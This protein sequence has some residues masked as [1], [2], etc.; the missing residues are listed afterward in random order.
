MSKWTTKAQRDT[1]K[2]KSYKSIP[3]EHYNQKN[4]VPKQF[5]EVWE[6]TDEVKKWV[7]E[8]DKGNWWTE[9]AKE[10]Y[11]IFNGLYD[12]GYYPEG[13]DLIPPRLVK[14]MRATAQHRKKT[15]IYENGMKE[16]AIKLDP[17]E[18]KDW[19]DKN[20]LQAGI[21]DT[22]SADSLAKHGGLEFAISSVSKRLDYLDLSLIHI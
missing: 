11:Y 21:I 20:S 17:T 16:S 9:E 14:E 5:A 19:V 3:A 15:D 8:K 7:K 13:C 2:R 10:F 6:Y 4:K 12:H 22:T 1:F 18:Y